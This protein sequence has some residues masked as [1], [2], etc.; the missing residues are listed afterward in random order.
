MGQILE[1]S[2]RYVYFVPDIGFIFKIVLCSISFLLL[3]IFIE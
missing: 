3:Y 1:H 2:S